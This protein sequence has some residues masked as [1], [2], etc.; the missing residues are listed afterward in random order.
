MAAGRVH[1]VDLAGRETPL[2]WLRQASEQYFTASQFLAQLLRQ[3][4]SRPQ[5]VQ[6]LLGSEALLPLKLFAVVKRQ[7]RVL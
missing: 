3:L 6:G 5:A 7:L 1:G 2:F 4:M